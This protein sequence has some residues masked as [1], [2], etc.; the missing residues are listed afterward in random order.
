MASKYNTLEEYH[1]AMRLK[2]RAWY[3]NNAEAKREYQKKYY[4]NNRE[5]ILKK[6]RDKYQQ[7]KKYQ[8]YFMEQEYFNL[9]GKIIL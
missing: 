6:K 7:N 5:A 3:K 8:I 2:S 4:R 9:I 1:E